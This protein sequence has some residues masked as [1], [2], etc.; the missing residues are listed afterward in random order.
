MIERHYCNLFNPSEMSLRSWHIF[1]GHHSVTIMKHLKF[2]KEEQEDECLEILQDCD[3]CLRAKQ[4]RSPFPQLNRRTNSLFELVHGDV[5]GP[6][7]EENLH[8]TKY[9]LTLVEDHSRVIWTYLLH[10]KDEVFEALKGYIIMVQNQFN[11]QIKAFRS[12]N[13]SEFVNI[14]VG[15]LFRDY[16]ILHQKTC[17][18]LPQQNGIVERRHRNLLETARALMFESGLPLRFWPFSILT[19]TW[20]INRNPSRILGWV[21]PYSVLF[22][23]DPNYMM[24]RPFGC[25]AYVIDLH[26]TRSKFS[27]RN[28]KCIFLGYSASHKGNL[29]FDLE[30]EKLL[31]SRDV[32]FVTYTY[33]F[34]NQENLSPT[35]PVLPMVNPNNPEHQ[36]HLMPLPQENW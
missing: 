20:L 16:G 2:I 18:N 5:W 10:S 3:V 21:S 32:H 29:L 6:Y 27:P 24:L 25:L 35:V 12:D 33:H 23:K 26:P 15:I 1:L 36:P 13:G 30:H 34:R 4:T 22:K 7:C 14:K 31:T 11:A 19:S 8:N 17:V 28:H 9:V